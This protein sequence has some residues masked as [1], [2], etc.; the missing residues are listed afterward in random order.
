MGSD[1]QQQTLHGDGASPAQFVMILRLVLYL[2]NRLDRSLQIGSEK[3]VYQIVD[4]QA[5]GIAL[6]PPQGLT[7]EIEGGE[8]GGG[9]PSVVDLAQD[10]VRNLPDEHI[11]L[12]QI[13]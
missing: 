4:G 7:P 13:I 8:E 6:F 3:A 11:N 9:F 2:T 5:T 12:R 1:Q 10:M